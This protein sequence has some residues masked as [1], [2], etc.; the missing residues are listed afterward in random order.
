MSSRPRAHRAEQRQ[1]AGERVCAC[2]RP[3]GR[4]GMGRHADGSPACDVDLR[5]LVQDSTRRVPAYAQTAR[6]AARHAA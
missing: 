4:A 5:Y 3:L 1:Q 2:G 6:Y